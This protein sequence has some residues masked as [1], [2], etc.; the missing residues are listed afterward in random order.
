[1]SK[2]RPKNKTLNLPSINTPRRKQED[3]FQSLM[4][5]KF[6]IQSIFDDIRIPSFDFRVTPSKK[7]LSPK[8]KKSSNQK[9]NY[10]K[11]R[12][13]CGSVEPS[14]D[15]KYYSKSRLKHKANLNFD[16]SR[17]EAHCVTPFESL[18]AN[19][20]SPWLSQEDPY[21][22]KKHAIDAMINTDLTLM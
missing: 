15:Y 16:R 17:V 7:Q 12:P 21:N 18:D 1:M 22:L 19:A 3:K 11:L 2:V 9:T 20:P 14:R 10:H 13:N 8:G 4:Y 6:F 5:R